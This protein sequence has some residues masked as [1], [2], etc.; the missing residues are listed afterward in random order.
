MS[1]SN[2]KTSV[3]R[4]AVGSLTAFAVCLMLC[5]SALQAT[6]ATGAF[7]P[8]KARTRAERALREGQYELAA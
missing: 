7:E 4:M 5:A 2:L 6:A 8:E 1:I 3:S